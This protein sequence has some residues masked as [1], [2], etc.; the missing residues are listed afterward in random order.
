M[1]LTVEG[2]ACR[3]TQRMRF[4]RLHNE[5]QEIDD[6]L[7]CLVDRTSSLLGDRV[8]AIYITGSLAYGDFVPGR[9]DIDG[10]CFFR[11]GPSAEDLTKY[12]DMISDLGKIHPTYEGK[13]LDHPISMSSLQD[14]KKLEE[15]LGFVNLT[16]LIQSGKLI[17]GREI[18]MSVKPPTRWELDTYMAQDIAKI[19]R[20]REAG[21]P[22]DIEEDEESIKEYSQNPELVLDWLL[23]PARVLYT[24]KTG[25]IGSKKTAVHQYCLSHD[26]RFKMW[27]EQALEYRSQKTEVIPEHQVKAIME[28][29]IDFFWHLVN[30]V[31]AKMGLVR[32]GEEEVCTP[33]EAVNRFRRLLDVA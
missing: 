26:D 32:K 2:E 8:G 3:L 24:M 16:S 22:C 10:F 6:L 19:L 9:S 29:A 1:V 14:R 7:G 15:D 27:L 13:I 12:D 11:E 31:Q 28:V 33:A 21:I 18:I 23:Y 20:K 5:D 30:L 17:Y 25:R 4:D